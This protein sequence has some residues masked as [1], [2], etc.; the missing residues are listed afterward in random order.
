LLVD[1]NLVARDSRAAA[2]RA[3]AL[4]EAGLDGVWCPERMTDAFLTSLAVI[5][6]TERI[7]IGTAVAVAF[8]RN[9]MLA[10]YGAWDLAASSRGRFTVGLGT[11]VQRHIEQRFGMPWS[12]PVERLRDFVAAMRAIWR[13]WQDEAPLD[14]RGTHYAHSLMTPTFRPAPHQYPLR[15]FIGAVGKR[16]I[17][18][19]A[20][21]A[22]GWIAHPFMTPAYFDAA[23]ELIAAGLAAAGRKRSEFT[24]VLPVFLLASDGESERAKLVERARRR[25]AFYASTATY[26]AVL[27]AE[28]YGDLQPELR[29][30]A[31]RDRWEEMAALVDDELLGR[32]AIVC[33]PEDVP[34]HVAQRWSGRVDRISPVYGWPKIDP[35]RLRAISAE[36]RTA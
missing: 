5:L 32:F 31:A 11:Q 27:D 24:V 29:A 25:I 1:E 18:S 10:A 13:S 26:R 9:P 12:S 14:Y 2:G 4:E 33:A 8:A 19:A 34:K 15:V 3:R 20:E 21:F 22:D 28:G 30:L 7:E 36:L 35:D 6:S 16:A 23:E 17:R